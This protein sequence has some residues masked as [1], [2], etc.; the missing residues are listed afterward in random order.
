MGRHL[1]VSELIG[2]ERDKIDEFVRGF[3]ERYQQG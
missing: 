1:E 2:L 3:R